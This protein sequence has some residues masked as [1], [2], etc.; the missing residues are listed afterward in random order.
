MSI[1]NLYNVE[2]DGSNTKSTSSSYRLKKFYE[3]TILPDAYFPYKINTWTNDIF[4]GR[5][6]EKN[7]PILVHDGFMK[8]IPNIPNVSVLDFVAEAFFDMREYFTEL[9][10]NGVHDGIS[11]PYGNLTPVTGYRSVY[12]EYDKQ[13]ETIYQVFYTQNRIFIENKMVAFDDFV[14]I[15]LK[16]LKKLLYETFFL[17]SSFVVSKELSI[18]STGLAL[19]FSSPYSYDDDRAK[20]NYYIQNNHF[21]I[22]HDICK[23]F[24]FRIDKNIPWR[25]VADLTS[26]AMEK[27]LYNH[28]LNN[29]KVIFEKRFFK[30]Y[31]TDIDLLKFYFKQFWNAAINKQ[32]NITI[33]KYMC[34]SYKNELYERKRMGESQLSSKYDN[35]YFNRLY[36]YIKALEYKKPWTQ[37]EFENYVRNANEIL[38]YK[39]VQPST[40]YINSLFIGHEAFTKFKSQLTVQSERVSVG[41][42]AKPFLGTAINF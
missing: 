1:K 36:I 41:S 35:Y 37:Q 9:S 3:E 26:P 21:D 6:D 19:E 8:N 7:N 31:Y 30:A 13:M 2:L 12:S 16:F 4:Y 23:R 27:Y 5:I 17:R 15:F 40:D 28:G 39:G 38:A 10:L 29:L 32:P 24:G 18:F 42:N 11:G 20:I 33:P 14:S 34:G 22:M 25:I